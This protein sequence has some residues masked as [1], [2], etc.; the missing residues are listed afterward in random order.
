MAPLG[1]LHGHQVLQIAAKIEVARFVQ[2]CVFLNDVGSIL[3]SF[4]EPVGALLATSWMP[5]SESKI[6][7]DF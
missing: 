2:K 4:W 3:S 5:K 1:R 7:V 6:E